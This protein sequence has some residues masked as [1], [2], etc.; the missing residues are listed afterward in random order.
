MI[1]RALQVA[2]ILA[3]LVVGAAAAALIVSQ[4]AWFKDWLRGF[5]VREANGYL[6]G[7][8]AI[9][10]LGGNLFFGAEL[11]DV[12][13]VA[14]GE[15]AVRVK[16]IGIG[17]SVI[18]FLSG[19]ITI[20][21]IRLNQPVVHLRH[22]DGGWNVA[23]LVK[24]QAQ[25]ADRTGPK[26][27]IS[28]G[29]IGI[30]DGVIVVEDEARPTGTTGRAGA[31][32][33]PSLPS[34]IDRLD[35]KAAFSYSPVNYTLDIGHV[36]FEARE[37]A[38]SL[39]SLSGKIST[40]ND[41]LYFDQVS[42]RSA[43]S[44][45]RVDGA[46]TAYTTRPVLDLHVSSEKLAFVELARVVPALAGLPLQPSLD[47][48][49]KG[50]L[51]RVH[52]VAETRSSAGE[53]AGDVT[54]DLAAPGR[55]VAGTVRL[56]HLN[57][58]PW[59]RGGPGLRSDLT[60]QAVI[61]LQIADRTR[62]GPLGLVSGTYDVTGPR[63]VIA[64]YD[65]RDVR[66]AGRI[67]N[68]VVHVRGRGAAYGGRATAEGTVT[69]GRA[70]RLDLRGTAHGLDL[71]RLPATLHA[72]R[73][74]TDI[75][76]AYTIAGSFGTTGQFLATAAFAPS[77][78]AGA[79][80]ASGSTVRVTLDRGALGYEAH[81][82][83]ANLDVQQLGR[84]LNLPT[85][86]VD[87][88]RTSLTG[89]FSVKGA[90]TS[91]A[92]LSLD[93]T[94][95]LQQSSMFGGTIP[96]MHLVTGIHD[97]GLQVT[98]KGDFASFD[99]A[100]LA[101]QPKLAGR[102]SGTA[103]MRVELAALGEA[104]RPDTIAAN[105]RM[106]LHDSEIGGITIARA[107][108]D[109]SF[110]HGAGD[111][112]TLHIAGPQG[113]VDANGHLDLTSSGE[114]R[115]S[116]TAAV[117]A[118]EEVG[119]MTGQSLAG[120]AN[121][122]GTLTGNLDD[123]TT[124]GTLRLS[125]L[126][127]P[128]VSLLA[129][130]S[131]YRVTMPGLD[132]ARA[133]VSADTTAS[134]V[135]AAG[136]KLTEAA[137]KTTWHDQTLGLDATLRDQARTLTAAGDV[138]LHPDHQEVHVR[139]LV[140]RTQGAEWRTEPG[141]QS[142]IQY[143]G[144]RVAIDRL[145]LVSGPQRIEAAGAF[146]RPDDRLKV[147]LS[148]VDLAA[149][150]RLAL[151]A[152]TIAGR[153]DATAELGGT[154]EAPG[155]DARFTIA[156]GAFRQFHYASFGGTVGYDQTGLRLDTRLDQAPGAWLA[157]KGT[158]P[159]AAL[160]TTESHTPGTHE[161][162][163]PG[164]GIDLA[165]TS[166]TLSL[167]L[168]EGFAPQLTKVSGTVQADLHVLGTVR[169]PHLQGHV[170]V[171][172][173][174]FTVA[175]LTKDGYTGLDTRIDFE[176]DR[177]RI[178]EFRL[179][180]EHKH[181]LTVSGDLAVHERALGQVQIAVHTDQFEVVD[182]ELADVKLTSDLRVTGEL[183]APRV[184]GSVAVHTGTINID[185]VLDMVSTGASSETPTSLSA[186]TGVPESGTI[187]PAS[188]G[189]P[190][191]AEL[192]SQG[193]PAAAAASAPPSATGY[194]ALALDVRLQVPDNLVVKGNDLNPSGT[195]PVSMGNV[196]VTLGGD[197]HATKQP[198]APLSLVG[199]VNTVRGTYDFQGR[200]FDIQRDGKIQFV[201]GAEINPRLDITA[202]RIISGVQAQ[203][204][205]RGSARRPQL[206]LS[207]QPPLDEADILSLIVF[208]QPS[209]QLGEGDQVSLASRA[210]S[211]ATG[212]VASSLA[213]SIGNALELDVFEVQTAPEN[214][215]GPSV[216]VG[217]QVGERLFVKFRQ[218]FGAQ[219]VSELILEYQIA[220]YLRFQTTVAEGAAATERTLMHRV[221]Q[222]GVDLIFYYTY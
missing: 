20:D 137:I 48:R 181:Q 129:A 34:R 125:S 146:G 92:T 42:V 5:I 73:M 21:H 81:G 138:V 205:V 155:A 44:A 1:R 140:L 134:L 77:T 158:V 127:A 110:A 99:P 74:A 211:L 109:G 79:Q 132:P 54:A 33:A 157:V 41:A 86:A 85:L 107:D 117:P 172:N 67:A 93:A 133:Q 15:P 75:T 40:R 156:D 148:A 68:G 19:G 177:V 144:G 145:A 121:V 178:G 13:L 32:S 189:L 222:G 159:A 130:T 220:Q 202:T 219:S 11:E 154:R 56:A 113:T 195:S 18:D 201:G 82:H 166:S 123:L 186:A 8:L 47:V 50:P 218:A 7:Q 29:S 141:S 39:R 124:T 176:P 212:F 4:T 165:V 206:A 168:A 198:R 36:S 53:V 16:D 69:P 12:S 88:F 6:N 9:G 60:G 116:Y 188:G 76:A 152:G 214:G 209:N 105:G 126:R 160:R 102:V 185:R 197:I 96:A 59:L 64:G 191:V 183:S 119:K 122:E 171:Q 24:R 170:D 30:S 49:A 89:D 57:L 23:S 46:V 51:D 221:E 184:E 217:E 111:I 2:A 115:L 58:A 62:G 161:T 78:V 173:G 187:V 22:T 182:N 215:T 143:A 10:R 131:E 52:L 200:R 199:T 61:D 192:P 27:P 91:L 72:P 150:D 163:A 135:E 210:S 153:L 196:N 100:T 87:R 38:F 71:Q 208:N 70:L 98:A 194:D 63:I 101:D 94:T 216:T 84:G 203:V 207:S 106:T 104:L 114:S 151:G 149:A 97:G 213:Q 25:E 139:D 147:T 45:L 31:A 193:T 175:D 17:Y 43:E 190:A 3:T 120:T 55:R 167:A 169:D 164:E 90:G 180:D 112:R 108:V 174:A 204:H 162:P 66:A 26:R 80:L 37:P 28:I 65:V 179:L 35:V 95:D 103:D 136:L 118:L 142:A 14:G 128:S 83:I